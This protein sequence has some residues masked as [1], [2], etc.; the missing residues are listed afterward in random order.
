MAFRYIPYLDIGAA[1]ADF[2]AYM[3][4]KEADFKKAY[5]KDGVSIEYTLADGIV[6]FQFHINKQKLGIKVAMAKDELAE[7][8]AEGL[9][10]RYCDTIRKPKVIGLA[11][12]F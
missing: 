10:Q 3:V 7:R 6:T 5:G 8:A 9:F 4:S 1:C 11:D 12:L 2:E